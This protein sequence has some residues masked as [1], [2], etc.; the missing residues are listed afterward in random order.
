VGLKFVVRT[1]DMYLNHQVPG[2]VAVQGLV[3]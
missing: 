1:G 2:P 3:R